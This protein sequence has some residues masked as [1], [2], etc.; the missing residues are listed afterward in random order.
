MALISWN[1]TTGQVIAEYP[2]TSPSAVDE[3]IEMAHLVHLD[4]K[5]TPFSHRAELMTRAGSILRER[6]REFG[7]LMTLE[8]GKPVSGGVAE[9][10]KCA[11]VCEYYAQ[12]AQGM[13]TDQEVEAGGSRSF[14]TFQPLGAV[15][16]VMP[17]NFPFWQVFRFAAPNLMAGNA[18]LLKHASNV[19]GCA[20]AIEE[21]F[22]EA[23]FP[24]GLF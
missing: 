14:I 2:E 21:V 7:E 19:P 17:W 18:G 8:M 9:A 11:W 3:A 15:L 5:R 16:A 6:A 24:D 23:G 12:N 20:L 1:P 22:R 4:W 10:E 13:L